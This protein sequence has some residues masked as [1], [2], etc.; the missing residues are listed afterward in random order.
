[1]YGIAELQVKDERDA[2]SDQ[3]EIDAEDSLS[4]NY[5]VDNEEYAESNASAD[6]PESKPKTG[7]LE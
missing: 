4:S 1:M 3:E 5:E 7:T 2:N 6:M